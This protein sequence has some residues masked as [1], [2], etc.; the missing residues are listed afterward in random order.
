MDINTSLGFFRLDEKGFII[1][2]VAACRKEFLEE[3]LE[4][5]IATRTFLLRDISNRPGTKNIFALGRSQVFTIRPILLY[6][7]IF[8]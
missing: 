2:F 6:S 8:Q 3:L 7:S 1:H 5:D 4:L